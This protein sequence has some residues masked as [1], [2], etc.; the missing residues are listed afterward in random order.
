MSAP[1]GS[2]FLGAHMFSNFVCIPCPLSPVP[3]GLDL[4]GA[5]IPF[6]F[7]WMSWRSEHPNTHFRS[8]FCDLSGPNGFPFVGHGLG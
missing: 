2:I 8:A 7:L 6:S 3:P 5:G 4:L 1:R